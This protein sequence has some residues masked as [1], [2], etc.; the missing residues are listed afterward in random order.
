MIVVKERLLNVGVASSQ[1]NVNSMAV[2]HVDYKLI[3]ERRLAREVSAE[4]T[5]GKLEVTY[6]NNALTSLS[7][8]LI[9]AKEFPSFRDF[10][11][12]PSCLQPK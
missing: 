5:L 7:D 6:S 8:M 12:I 2:T 4:L 9:T 3:H 11:I 1:Q 10:N